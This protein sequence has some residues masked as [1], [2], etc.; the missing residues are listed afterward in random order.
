[1]RF[2][3]LTLVDIT[4]TD[5]RRSDESSLYK[6][7]QNF[8]SVVQTISLRANPIIESE[9]VCTKQSTK[10]LGFGSE[11]SGDHAV[12]TLSFSFEQ[13]GSHNLDL[14][15]EDFDMV[16]FIA[17]LTETAKF[18]E[19]AFNTSNSKRVNIIFVETKE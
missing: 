1:M 2:K 9:P 16:P 13:A 6:Q 15:R 10:G 19:L 17:G 11:F 5:A 12:W 18:K 14:L 7:Q 8:F 3:L 4:K